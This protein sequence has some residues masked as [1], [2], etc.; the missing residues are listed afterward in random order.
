MTEIMLT[1]VKPDP[2]RFSSFVI[3]GLDP[4]IQRTLA[5]A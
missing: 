5:A 1:S 4:G 3:P 2:I